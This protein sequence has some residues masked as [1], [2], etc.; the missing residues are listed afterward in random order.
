[1]D[2][3]LHLMIPYYHSPSSPQIRA[4]VLT[5]RW[6]QRRRRGFIFCLVIWEEHICGSGESAP[7]MYY[8]DVVLVAR[9][10]RKSRAE[11][12][13]QWI[14]LRAES[15]VV[16]NGTLWIS[17]DTEQGKRCPLCGLW[18]IWIYRHLYSAFGISGSGKGKACWIDT[19]EFVAR[20]RGEKLQNSTMVPKAFG[21]LS[22]F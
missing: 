13:R 18:H 9:S 19:E 17:T 5:G 11:K 14:T 4:Q 8:S 1:M 15:D 22:W 21:H 20:D 2:W 3:G 16:S 7:C 12:T 6:W 10:D